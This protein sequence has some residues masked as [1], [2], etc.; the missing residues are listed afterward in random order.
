M[1]H[2]TYNLAKTNLRKNRKLY[3]P[4]A[5]VTLMS[6]VTVYLLASLSTNPHLSTLEYTRGVTSILRLGQ[7]V[8]MI[9]VAILLFYANQF[10]LKNRTKELG[11]YAILGLEKRHL[12]LMTLLEI[13]LFSSLTV[14]IGLLIGILLDKLI[15]AILLKTIQVPVVLVSVFQWSNLL[16]V[17]VYFFLV[18]CLVAIVNAGKLTFTSSLQLVKESK[19][20]EGKG[21]WLLLQTIL[22]MVLLVSGYT[23]SQID[24]SPINILTLF[25]YAV[26]LVIGATYLL[27]N[28]GIILLLKSLQRW[29]KYYYQPSNFISVSNLVFRMRKNAMGLATITILSTMFLV[30]MIGG[31]GI[32]VGIDE[33]VRRLNP[34]DLY[35]TY[36]FKTAADQTSLAE[37]EEMAR[38]QVIT[39]LD[40]YGIPVTDLA[41]YTY[42]EEMVPSINENRVQLVQENSSKGYSMEE[43]TALYI[44]DEVAYR[45]MT[46]E[47]LDLSDQEVAVYAHD[48][49]VNLEK[50]LLIDKQS[51]K[52]KQ[53]LPTNIT[54]EYLPTMMSYLVPSMLVI[55]HDIADITMDVS[56]QLYVGVDTDLDEEKQLERWGDGTQFAL[57]KA[58]DSIFDGQGWSIRASSRKD[59]FSSSGSM[60]F[61][62]VFLS[63][64]FLMATALVIYYK[65]ISEAYEDRTRF[66]ILQKVGL[67]EDQTTQS[68]RKQLLTVFFFP[69]ILAFIHL[70]FAYKM[71]H[72]ILFLLGVFDTRII[73]RITLIGG[74]AYFLLYVAVYAMTSYSYRNII[75]LKISP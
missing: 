33:A 17:L 55:V 42:I 61:I 68:I 2:T 36:H 1:W 46:G 51:F 54:D 59:M 71:L 47:A 35:F 63:L 7:I 73:Y 29:Q 25:F 75:R 20:G 64:V 8:V 66:V 26:L 24:A 48:I 13:G 27:F 6:V 10:V 67:D 31:V 9:V 38:R 45:Q 30:T 72:N 28:A 58:D 43:G 34:N 3:Y 41:Q 60:M 65:Q 53:T 4:F 40:S 23:L 50:N 11:V 18:F 70:T 57:D 74:L 56:Y 39:S 21:R 49:D 16:T 44:I 12:L 62:G 32:Y 19:R 37:A 14:A 69:L 15:Y 22:G 52:I 5:L